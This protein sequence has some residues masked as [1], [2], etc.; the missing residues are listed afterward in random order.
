[1]GHAA[2]VTSIGKNMPEFM[3]QCKSTTRIAPVPLGTS[4]YDYGRPESFA[5]DRHTSQAKV[6]DLQRSDLNAKAVQNI[7]DINEARPCFT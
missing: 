7:S 3:S 2:R 6:T 5:R 1:M 4:V